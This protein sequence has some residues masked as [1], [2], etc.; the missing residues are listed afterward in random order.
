MP[1]PLVTDPLSLEEW[2]R[3]DRAGVRIG[4]E[5]RMG[6]NML[7]LEAR[8]N[9]RLLARTLSLDLS[10]CQSVMDALRGGEVGARTLMRLPGK[11]ATLRF[12]RGLERRLGCTIEPLT[13]A[14]DQYARVMDAL[15]TTHAIACARIDGAMKDPAR[16]A[17]RAR[18]WRA[19]REASFD[20][21]S[22]VCDAWSDVITDI[23]ILQ[24]DATDPNLMME[25]S[26]TSQFGLRTRGIG[27]PIWSQ[28]WLTGKDSVELLSQEG[29][30]REPRPPML[31]K[32]FSTFPLPIVSSRASDGGNMNLIDVSL[33]SRLEH[34]DVTQERVASRLPTPNDE[35]PLWSSALS[36]R[37]P[38]R[39]M[40]MNYFV[41]RSMAER[42]LVSGAGYFWTPG[43]TGDP[44]RHWYE[45]HP[46]VPAVESLG[47]TLDRVAHPAVPALR[48]MAEYLFA[49][50]GASPA[51]YVGYRLDIEFPTWGAVY[52]LTFDFR[53]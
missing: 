28:A 5:L 13:V 26:L 45:Q 10:L 25:T 14:V 37:I 9:A 6:I 21:L 11:S 1:Q 40:I 4:A 16:S 18:G 44:A 7:P 51:D 47:R 15:G 27:Y 23:G 2:T 41:P 34:V 38:A 8:G 33:D 17:D 29:V 42:S 36:S 3:I 53:A 31:V 35:D 48:R 39:R 50:C 12:V 32:E 30:A 43:L 20:A 52:Y 49:R 24:I 19:A 46:G 22:K